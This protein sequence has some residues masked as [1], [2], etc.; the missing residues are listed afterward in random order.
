M[1]WYVQ[2]WFVYLL[3]GKEG[4]H[5]F[6]G[7]FVEKQSVKVIYTSLVCVRASF[8]VCVKKHI[9]NNYKGLLEG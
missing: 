3:D 1:F 8:A 5:V 4:S 9:F 7:Y 2:T 6:L